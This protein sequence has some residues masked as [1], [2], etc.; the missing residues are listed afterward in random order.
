MPGDAASAGSGGLGT[1]KPDYLGHFSVAFVMSFLNSVGEPQLNLEVIRA[2]GT[3]PCLQELSFKERR[4]GAFRS[5]DADCGWPDWAG[6]P[7]AQ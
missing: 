5:P 7:K 2:N 6:W 3:A 4:C 1:E